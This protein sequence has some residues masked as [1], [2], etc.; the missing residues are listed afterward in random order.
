M[1]VRNKQTMHTGDSR[2]LVSTGQLANALD[3][4][5]RWVRDLAE[6]GILPRV[7]RGV[8][9]LADCAA[10]YVQYLKRQIKNGD[11]NDGRAR[12]VKARASLLELRLAKERGEVLPLSLYRS[13]LFRI[14]NSVREGVLR[15]PGQVAGEL[16]GLD[17]GRI[18]DVL[19]GAVREALLS[20][21]RQDPSRPMPTDHDD[22]EG[23]ANLP[24]NGQNGRLQ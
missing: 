15:I 12:L 6:V 3:L 14:L 19:D 13:E 7:R 11:A 1:K 10:R 23:E 9:D 5:G 16:V 24:P 18:Q 2:L 8:F 17:A 4:S 20:L 21:S 22:S